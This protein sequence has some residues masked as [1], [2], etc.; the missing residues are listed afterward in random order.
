MVPT[1]DE[2]W[3]AITEFVYGGVSCSFPGCDKNCD[4][5]NKNKKLSSDTTKLT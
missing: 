1:T 4:T 3:R 2:R 5:K